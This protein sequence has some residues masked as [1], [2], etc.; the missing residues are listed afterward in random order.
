MRPRSPATERR[1]PAST[2]PSSDDILNLIEVGNGEGKVG[3][4]AYFPSYEE[5]DLCLSMGWHVGPTNNQDNH[6][7]NWGSSNTCRDV[8][9]T[10]DFSEI[11]IY[12]ALDA[13][14]IYATEDQ[15]LE[16][17]YE[18]DING[19]SYKLGDIASIEDSQQ[20]DQVTIRLTVNEPDREDIGTIQIIGEGAKVIKEV[21]VSGNSYKGD[22]V[23]DHK[24]ADGSLT[25]GYY[26]V[27]IIEADGNIAVTAPIWTSEAVP[28]N[29]DASTSAAVAAQGVEETVTAELTNGSESETVLLN[30][31]KITADGDVILE[32]SDLSEELAPGSVK[33]LT[34][35]FTPKTTDPSATKTYEIVAEFTFTYKGKTQ[36]YTKTLTE[37]SYPP[38]LKRRILMQH[39]HLSNEQTSSLL[40]RAAHEGLRDVYLCHLSANNNTP[41]IA[42]EAAQKTLGSIGSRASLHCLPRS[43][44]SDLFTF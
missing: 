13:R 34:A 7:G 15:N 31:W 32:A 23:I 38:E 24:K 33:T 9:L 4:S 30:G 12:R 3:G 17:Y 6:K 5:Y 27:K 20:P 18:M 10:D 37:T 1:S 19:Q 2:P 28:V 42:F 43:G 26:Y 16:I 44:A 25:S 29:V 36:T 39:G 40:R 21:S 8:V 11:G 41:R 14:R 22:I 35:P